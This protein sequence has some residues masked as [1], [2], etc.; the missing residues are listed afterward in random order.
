MHASA[1]LAH[2][3]TPCSRVCAPR[4]AAR[5]GRGGASGATIVAPP[6]F[7]NKPFR[8]SNTEKALFLACADKATASHDIR[9]VEPWMV[10]LKTACPARASLLPSS[11]KEP[12]RKRRNAPRVV[13]PVEV[14]PPS[15]TKNRG[16]RSR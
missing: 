12:P 9:P 6:F 15:R 8:L 4:V 5:P 14:S 2:Q 16:S 11:T 3:K 7:F 1:T 13:T 10:G